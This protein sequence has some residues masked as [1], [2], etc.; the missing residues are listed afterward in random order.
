MRSNAR[1]DRFEYL[2]SD[3]DWLGGGCD[4][5]LHCNFQFSNHLYSYGIQHESVIF[6]LFI[7]IYGLQDYQEMLIIS[8][9]YT[10][11]VDH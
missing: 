8:G 6:T 3:G 4:C 10:M 1:L 2:T 5:W 9:I 7:R 11:N